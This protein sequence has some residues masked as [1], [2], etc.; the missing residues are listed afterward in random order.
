MGRSITAPATARSAAA[1]TAASRAASFLFLLSLPAAA[2]PPAPAAEGPP[3][4]PLHDAPETDAGRAP[5]A[6]AAGNVVMS[7]ACVSS[8]RG[9]AGSSRPSAPACSADSGSMA[10]MRLM[11]ARRS[12]GGM[13]TTVCRP[14][15]TRPSSFVPSQLPPPSC[16]A[17]SSACRPRLHLV[18]VDDS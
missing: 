6:S 8:S 2:A 4:P 1:R 5:S 15:V 7:L 10:V 11:T 18:E 13:P 3:V 17:A 16:N 14:R 12:P 9:T